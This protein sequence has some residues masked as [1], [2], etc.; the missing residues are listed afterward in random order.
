MNGIALILLI[1][2][3]RL[4]FLGRQFPGRPKLP[5][6]GGRGRVGSD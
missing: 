5:I 1:Y 3:K 4:I 2:L 6:F